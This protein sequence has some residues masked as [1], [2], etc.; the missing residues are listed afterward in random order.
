MFSSPGMRQ[1]RASFRALAVDGDWHSC[2]VHS[3][4]NSHTRCPSMEECPAQHSNSCRC[5]FFMFSF[6]LLFAKRCSL[7]KHRPT[8][9]AARQARPYRL[10]A[11]P[12]ASWL[13]QQHCFRRAEGFR[14]CHTLPPAWAGH[15]H[16]QPARAAQ[17]WHPRG[18]GCIASGMR[19]CNSSAQH[20]SVA[21]ST[22][23]CRQAERAMYG[24]QVQG[25]TWV[26]S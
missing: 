23:R 5:S 22:H 18:L 24:P 16:T 13:R 8:P 21:C 19:E 14:C 26:T 15:S 1:W 2:T 9:T 11:W 20:S 4:E 12:P 17:H 6:T 3:Q 10:L 25:A 7:V